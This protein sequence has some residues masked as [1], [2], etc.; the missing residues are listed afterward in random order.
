MKIVEPYGFIYITTNLINGKR[1]IGQK[2]FINNWEIYLGSGK[3]LKKAIK[4]YGKDN[5]IRDIVDIAYNKEQLNQ[6]EKEWIKNYKAVG[7][8]MYYN[9]ANGGNGGNG[10]LGIHKNVGMDNPQYGLKGELSVNWKRKFTEKHRKNLSLAMKNNPPKSMEGKHHSNDAK[11]K[12]REKHSKKV[13]C[14]NTGEIF[15]SMLEAEKEMRID[16]HDISKCCRGIRE[17]AG[18][19][20]SGEKLKWEFVA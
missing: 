4:K 16:R 15:K 10:S 20:S 8:D 3:I 2:Q 14:I 9:I 11:Q 1:Y 17:F 6:L 13:I 19:L 7:E 12:I 5:F 18:K